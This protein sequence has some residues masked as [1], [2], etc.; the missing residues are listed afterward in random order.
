MSDR[1]AIEKNKRKLAE[2]QRILYEMLCELDRVCKENKIPYMLFAGTALGAVR[3]HDFIPW[4]DDLDVVMLRKDYRRFLRCAKSDLDPKVYYVQQEF[5]EHWPMQFSKIRKNH[6][7]CMERYVPKDPEIHQGIY[8][9]VFP[10]DNLSDNRLV[11]KLQFLASKVVIAKALDARGYLTDSAAKKLFM[12]VCRILPGSL[13]KKLVLLE[14]KSDSRM[15][16]TFFGAS[17]RYEKSIYPRSFFT[18]Y[19]EMRFG[20]GNFPVSANY[21]ELLTILYGDYMTPTPEER[22]ERKVHAEIVDPAHSYK[23]YLD[24]QKSMQFR[25]YTRSIR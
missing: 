19:T 6:T 5:S 22:R 1:T 20:E 8:L 23:E 3:E 4:D 10:C 16:H 12:A 2:H 13:F 14:S 17:S 25:E 7:A 18:E 15:V 11:R 24:Q 21:H 9:D